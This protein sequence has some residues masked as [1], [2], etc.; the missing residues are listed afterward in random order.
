M[1]RVGDRE[2]HAE[3]RG[4]GPPLLLIQGMSGHSGH[5]GDALLSALARDFEVVVYDHRG[6]G[7][8]DPAE[9]DFAMADLAADAAGVLDGLGIGS[10]HVVGASMGGM[11]AQEL[12]LAGPARV[13]T[14]TLGAT[15]LGGEH[16]V[17]PA[18]EVMQAIG[19]ALLA[20]DP[21][22]TMRTGY[23]VNL[24]EGHRADPASWEAFRAAAVDR[25]VT[26]EAR[27]R[28]MKAVAAFDTTTRAAA[29]AA[30]TLVVHGTADRTVPIGN[31]EQVAQVIPGARLERLEGA[32]HFFWLEQPGRT[33]ELVRG[34]ALAADPVTA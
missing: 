23:E 27:I 24:S 8:S 11:V 26:A 16:T 12:A 7:R 33:A 32:A 22:L 4:D 34:H 5:W 13:R 25:P 28:F 31:G 1:I 19:E 20:Q 2:L 10:A 15:I 14:L 30:P 3:R 17:R 21:E 9:E 6:T 18:P 29:I